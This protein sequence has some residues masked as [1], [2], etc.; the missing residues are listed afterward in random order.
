MAKS[1]TGQPAN[2][3]V[4]SLAD[5]SAE[6][7]SWLKQNRR[8]AALIASA[9]F[10]AAVLVTLLIPRDYVA[11]MVVTPVE[12]S[13]TDP[14]ALMTSPGFSIRSPFS[15][16]SGAPPQMA[17]FIK[18]LKSPEVARALAANPTAMQDIDAA[19]ASWTGA[20]KRFLTGGNPADENARVFQVQQ[21]LIGHI[22]VDQDVDVQTWTISLRYPT[23]EGATYLLAAVHAS[24]E[25]ILRRAAMLQFAKEKKYGLSFL[26][27]TTDAQERQIIYGILDLID[28]SLLVLRSGANVATTVISSPYAPSGPSYPSHIMTFLVVTGGMTFLLFVALVARCY[29]AIQRGHR[30]DLA[31][32]AAATGS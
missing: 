1:S 9:A 6:M 29:R 16:T 13:L 21:W 17:A 32:A 12:T 24:A 26:N 20:I 27:N 2:N 14:S 28:R 25:D 10:L 8:Y 5:L 11:T 19:Q 15:L 3:A 31:P 30:A 4:P 18:L 22:A 7:W 23:Q